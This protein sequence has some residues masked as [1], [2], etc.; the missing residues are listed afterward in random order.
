MT[1]VVQSTEPQSVG[2][3]Q[4]VFSSFGGD[5]SDVSSDSA[6]PATNAPETPSPEELFGDGNIDWESVDYT[7][8]DINKLPEQYRPLARQAKKMQ[9]SFTRAQQAVREKERLL[10]SNLTQ[11]QQLQRMAPQ[12]Q[13]DQATAPP[14]EVQQLQ[15]FLGNYGFTPE[16]AGYQEYA[17]VAKMIHDARQQ[18]LQ[19]INQ[20]AQV[21]SQLYQAQQQVTG[22]IQQTQ[23]QPYNE[24]FEAAVSAGHDPDDIRQYA[25]A[26]IPLVDQI[27]NPATGKPHTIQSAY[28]LVSGKAAQR[29]AEMQTQ[30]QGARRQARTRTSVPPNGSS[31]ASNGQMTDAELKAELRKLGFT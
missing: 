31:S 18:D 17:L 5:A 3:D 21:V 29:S 6:E 19:Q 1:E 20:L 10:D 8:L 24:Q 9:A 4:S 11:M 7:K 14:S 27:V 16:T 2:E 28:E 23:V 25:Q 26:L 30:A 13:N 15:S 12:A 22:H